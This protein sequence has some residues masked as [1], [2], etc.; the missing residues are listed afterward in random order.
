MTT[1]LTIQE[2]AERTGLTA[3][4]LRYYERIGLVWEVDRDTA[5]HR[6]YTEQDVG[7]LILLTRLRA[8][9]MRVRDMLR[10]AELARQGPETNPARIRLLEEQRARVAARIAELQSDLDLLDYKITAY[11]A[12]QAE[13]NPVRESA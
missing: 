12:E 11:R 1:G 3:H 9:G 8:T 10:Y 7:W 2:T 4:T 13:P 6:R 5:G